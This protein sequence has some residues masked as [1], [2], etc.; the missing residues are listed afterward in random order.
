MGG[1]YIIYLPLKQHSPMPDSTV[2]S[3]AHGS[4]WAILSE[5]HGINARPEQTLLAAE[6]KRSLVSNVPLIAEAPTG[7]G[8]TLA[9]L[10]A[11]VEASRAM[12]IPLLIGTATVALQQQIMDSEIPKMRDCGLIGMGEVV[13]VKGR[14][15]YFCPALAE[16]IASRAVGKNDNQFSLQLDEQDTNANDKVGAASDAADLLDKY[17]AGTWDGDRDTLNHVP[18]GWDNY[19]SEGDTCQGPSC[20]FHSKNCP[21]FEARKEALNAKIVVTNHSLMLTDF[22]ARANGEQGTLPHSGYLVV[23]DE[24]HHLPQKAIESA[25]TDI[26]LDDVNDLIT[27]L[28]DFEWELADRPG[29][30]QL[31]DSKGLKPRFSLPDDVRTNLERLRDKIGRMPVGVSRVAEVSVET[32]FLMEKLQVS[33]AVAASNFNAV[34]SAF[35]R[36]KLNPVEKRRMAGMVP[37]LGKTKSRLETMAN[38]LMGFID[39]PVRWIENPGARLHSSP[40]TAEAA[41]KSFFWDNERMPIRPV[42]V[43]A[44]LLGS[45]GWARFLKKSAAPE[46][47]KTMSLPHV[48]NYKK[49]RL[50]MPDLFF[51]PKSPEYVEESHAW[52]QSEIKPTEGTL[53]LFNSRAAMT[54]ALVALREKFG[55]AVLAQGDKGVQSLIATHKGRIDAGKGSVLCGLNTLAEGLDLPGDYVR[56]VVI[57]QLPFGSPDSPLEAARQEYH[58]K[59]YFSDVLVP[60]ATT[61]LTQMVGRLIRRTTD[62]GRVSVLDNR[63]WQT[64][65]G[66]EMLNALPPFSQCIIRLF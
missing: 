4:P 37:M 33:A 29:I 27:E 7:I 46:N 44:T 45:N 66:R 38:G 16:R 65:W 36:A 49:S 25:A 22:K 60:D 39:N 64:R 51:T 18:A 53:V 35:Q 23:I 3:P 21:Y 13:M 62:I 14:G 47:T 15:R 42:L 8:K 43:S 63:L 41:M 40:L 12:N 31:L 28:S 52:L 1:A 58:G 57:T 54:R 48:F 5:R 19:R 24:A 20:E 50:V 9:Y 10:V 32:K 6:I 26:G 2:A 61:R 59:A 34:L 30:K 56:H 55:D 11:G 17:R